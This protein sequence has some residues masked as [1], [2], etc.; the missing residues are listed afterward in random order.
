M[1]YVQTVLLSSKLHMNRA[2]DGDTV[3]IEILPEAQWVMPN[4]RLP[5]QKPAPDRDGSAAEAAES[6]RAAIV[7]QVSAY[8]LG[9]SASEQASF[10]R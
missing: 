8:F 7:P 2:F 10:V 9:S 3:A 5:A 4:S 1:P 6:A